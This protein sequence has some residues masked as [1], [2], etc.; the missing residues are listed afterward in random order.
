MANIAYLYVYKTRWHGSVVEIALDF[1]NFQPHSTL[2]MMQSKI[3]MKMTS[4]RI[5]P[6]FN[7]FQ[8]YI[9]LRDFIKWSL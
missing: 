9:K 8:K 2:L 7:Y 5:L 1:T 3:R 6:N 4:Y